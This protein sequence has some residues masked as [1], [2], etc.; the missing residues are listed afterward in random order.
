[1]II[2]LDTVFPGGYNGGKMDTHAYFANMGIPLTLTLCSELRFG[3]RGLS[4]NS[5]PPKGRG[6]ERT[7]KLPLL[8]SL[9]RTR[10][11][12][13]CLRHYDEEGRTALSKRGYS[14]DGRRGGPNNEIG[15]IGSAQ[16]PELHPSGVIRLDAFSVLPAHLDSTKRTHRFADGK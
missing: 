12:P 14:G 13:S 11:R 8:V 15:A 10:R 9:W 6:D 5:V 16:S 4:S 2:L 1:M 7:A 3:V